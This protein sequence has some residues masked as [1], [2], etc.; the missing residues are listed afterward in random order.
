MPES[1]G[2]SSVS[3][4][5]NPWHYD[6]NKICSKRQSSYENSKESFFLFRGNRCGLS[7]SDSN[8]SE[9]SSDKKEVRLWRAVFPN[10]GYIT[11]GYLKSALKA[12]LQNKTHD[13]ECRICQFDIDTGFDHICFF[14]CGRVCNIKRFIGDFH[15]WCSIIKRANS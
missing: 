13:S 9:G 15:D 2:Q 7:S 10:L 14:G 6:M 3:L 5:C 4:F 8:A 11:L 12:F 1:A